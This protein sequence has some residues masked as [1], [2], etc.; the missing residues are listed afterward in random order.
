MESICSFNCNPRGPQNSLQHSFLHPVSICCNVN[1]HEVSKALSNASA[2]ES[3]L[4]LVSKKTQVVN[5]AFHT[6]RLFLVAS[7]CAVAVVTDKMP[8]HPQITLIKMFPV[9]PVTSFH[10]PC[11]KLNFCHQSDFL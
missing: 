8:A 1:G 2:S 3:T 6:L 9:K 11:R 7:S 10:R 4:A 5:G